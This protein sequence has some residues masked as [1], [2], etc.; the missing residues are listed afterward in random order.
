[1]RKVKSV[2]A[3]WGGGWGGGGGGGFSRNYTQLD[4]IARADFNIDQG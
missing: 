2:M 1:M 4:R 3:G